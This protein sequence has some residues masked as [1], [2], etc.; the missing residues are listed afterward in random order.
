MIF[1]KWKFWIIIFKSSM[2]FN[3]FWFFFQLIATLGILL[4]VFSSTAQSLWPNLGEKC[5]GGGAKLKYLSGDALIDSTNCVGP[6][7]IPYPS[8]TI[9]RAFSSGSSRKGRQS[10]LKPSTVD[11]MVMQS[12]LLNAYREVNDEPSST[13]HGKLNISPQKCESCVP[14]EIARRKSLSTGQDRF[15]HLIAACGLCV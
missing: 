14:L 2:L 7:N 15:L 5:N 1:M 3:E 10:Q 12:T 13:R 8:S 11:P 9:N 4:G 6:N